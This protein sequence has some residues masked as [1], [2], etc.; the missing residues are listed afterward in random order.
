MPQFEL[1]EAF[2]YVRIVGISKCHKGFAAHLLPRET[3]AFHCTFIDVQD[4]QIFLVDDK[5]RVGVVI[6]Q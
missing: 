5:Y 3:V 2:E 4:H 1:S 6:E